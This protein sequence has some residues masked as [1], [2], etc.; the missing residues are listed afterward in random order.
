MDMSEINKACKCLFIAWK[1]FGIS[2]QEVAQAFSE[3]FD[4]VIE[5]TTCR[6]EDFLEYM[7]KEAKKPQKPNGI[8]TIKY[9]KRDYLRNQSISTYRVDKK[10]QKNLPYQ[11]RNY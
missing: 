7:Q 2:L 8:P 1:A 6:F 3:A 4:N 5:E 9:H 10:V 11:R